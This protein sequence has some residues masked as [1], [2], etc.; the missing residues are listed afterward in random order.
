MDSGL[1]KIYEDQTGANCIDSPTGLLNHGFYEMAL[2]RDFERAKR[3]D[4]T[5]IFDALTTERP[6]RKA[7]SR[8]KALRILRQD[9]EDGKLDKAVVSTFETLF[10]GGNDSHEN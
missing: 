9:A 1:I 4:E 7:M 2:C 3:Y 8:E 10:A 5:V 6:Y